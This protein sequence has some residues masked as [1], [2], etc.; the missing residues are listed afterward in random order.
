MTCTCLSLP[1]SHLLCAITHGR[2][3]HGRLHVLYTFCNPPHASPHASPHHR[4]HDRPHGLRPAQVVAERLLDEAE[5]VK[6]LHVQLRPGLREADFGSTPTGGRAEPGMSGVVWSVG[7][8]LPSN[9]LPVMARLSPPPE[10][11]LKQPC[12]RPP[13]LWRPLP[14]CGLPSSLCAGASRAR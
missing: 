10:T 12:Y 1:H 5:L 9:R 13:P 4:P 6:G 14:L 8:R 2:P 11:A 3:T 7:A